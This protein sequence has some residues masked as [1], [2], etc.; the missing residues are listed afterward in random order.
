MARIWAKNKMSS[1]AKLSNLSGYAQVAPKDRFRGD[2]GSI[3]ESASR[4]MPD[5]AVFAPIDALSS[6]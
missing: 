5:P 2:P 6:I 3:A 4:L 1:V